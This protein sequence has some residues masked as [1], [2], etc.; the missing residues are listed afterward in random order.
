MKVIP[1]LLYIYNFLHTFTVWI[2][3]SQIEQQFFQ[4]LYLAICSTLL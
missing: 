1:L 3:L 2:K 4:D